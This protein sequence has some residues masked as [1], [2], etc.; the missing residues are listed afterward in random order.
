VLLLYAFVNRLMRRG[1][2]FKSENLAY[3]LKK[4]PGF[5]G[6]VT[7]LNAKTVIFSDYCQ[8]AHY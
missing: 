2:H 8:M 5:L 6:L 4:S 1:S 3:G 7:A